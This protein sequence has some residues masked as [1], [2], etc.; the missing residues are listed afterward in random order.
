[1]SITNLSVNVYLTLTSGVYL[2]RCCLGQLSEIPAGR[3]YWNSWSLEFCVG[4]QLNSYLGVLF[5]IGGKNQ[6]GV[7]QI[8]DMKLCTYLDFSPFIIF[9]GHCHIQSMESDSSIIFADLTS[10]EKKSCDSTNLKNVG[11]ESVQNMDVRNDFTN[12][13]SKECVKP[14]K[15]GLSIELQED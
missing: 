12:S 6:Y 14:N 5:A 11:R 1:M 4:K 7:S 10:Q 8:H 3:K 13:N 9:S 15:C 2:R